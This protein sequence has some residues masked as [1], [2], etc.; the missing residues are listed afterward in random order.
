MFFVL[1][2]ILPCGENGL[3]RG[4]SGGWGGLLDWGWRRRGRGWGDGRGG[5]LLLP[6]LVGVGDEG[7]G[8]GLLARSNKLVDVLDEVGQGSL[9]ILDG[10]DMLAFAQKKLS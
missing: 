10:N 2:S 3:Y 1:E 9:L 4:S 8:C 6:A 5:G 7:E